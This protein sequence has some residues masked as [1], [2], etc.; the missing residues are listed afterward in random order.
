MIIYHFKTKSQL[1]AALISGLE[2]RFRQEFKKFQKTNPNSSNLILAFW[3]FMTG[4][5][6][7]RNLLKLSNEITFFVS[8]RKK[9]QKTAHKEI[10]EWTKLL[11][12]TFEDE[13]IA[14]LILI[15][16]QGAIVDLFMTN[17]TANGESSI[18]TLQALI[19]SKKKKG[20]F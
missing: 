19:I 15:T 20:Y 14:N 18:E 7:R 9:L 17:N 16:F 3:I 2:G 4:T 10:D 11:I 1:E 5:K 12:D 6:I 8:Q 13:K